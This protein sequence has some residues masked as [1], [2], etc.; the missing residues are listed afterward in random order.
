VKKNIKIDKFIQ[1]PISETISNV[2][3]KQKAIYKYLFASKN[4][5]KTIQY[6]INST[7]DELTSKYNYIKN[8]NRLQKSKKPIK[9][10]FVCSDI[11]HTDFVGLYNLIYFDK[12]FKI[13]PIIIIPDNLIDSETINEEKMQRMTSFFASFDMKVIDGVDRQTKELACIHAFKP[14]LVFYQKPIHIK[15]DFNPIKMSKNALTF[16]IEYDVR[17]EDSATIGSKY[18]HKQ[19]SNMWK[20]FINNSQDKKLYE[21][22]TN[23]QN[24]D[25]AKIV[26]KNINTATLKYLKKAFNRF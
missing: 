18:F 21:E 3:N 15:S 20:I 22:Y 6:S 4:I 9:V 14:D 5:F 7:T 17:N 8:L 16:T 24:K 10:A 1:I 2:F 11:T 26:T 25:I 13:F 23:I 19:V 12:D